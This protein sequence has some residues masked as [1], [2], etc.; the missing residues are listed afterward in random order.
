MRLKKENMIQLGIDVGG[1]GIKGALVDI[2]SGNITSERHRITTP[3]PATPDAIAKTIKQIADFFNYSGNIG[4]GF[5]AAIQNGV[6]KTASNIDPS[7]IGVNAEILFSNET[8]CNVTVLNDA[9]VA[10]FAEMMFCSDDETT[11]V[12]IFITVGTGIGSAIF[13]NKQLLPNTEFGHV[14]LDNGKKAE[15]YTADIIRKKENLS[16]T[17]WGKRF[18]KYL[19]YMENLFYPDLFIIGGGVSKKFEKYGSILN[20]KTKVIPATLKNQAGIIG[21]AILAKKSHIII[22]KKSE[23]IKIFNSAF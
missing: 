6:V 12:V 22:N 13:V 18:S 9:D 1:S 11:G 14:Y 23:I 7:W 15:H 19:Q 4:V 16:W 21:A 20:T 8:G 10:G 17:K 3:N 5:P 2:N